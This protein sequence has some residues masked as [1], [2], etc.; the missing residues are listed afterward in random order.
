MLITPQQWTALTIQ[1]RCA[2]LWEQF[3]EQTNN[4]A[5]KTLDEKYSTGQVMLAN[6]RA[7]GNNFS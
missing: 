3:R 2:G 1:L 6:W 5:Y 7:A 4:G